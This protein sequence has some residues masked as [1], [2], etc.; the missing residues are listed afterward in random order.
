MVEHLVAIKGVVSSI[1]TAPTRLSAGL[2]T[3]SNL[4]LCFVG[5]RQWETNNAP[6]TQGSPGLCPL[7]NGY[8]TAA[9]FQFYVVRRSRIEP[10]VGGV[11]MAERTVASAMGHR[12]FHGMSDIMRAR[13]Q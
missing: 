13:G 4:E 6:S 3:F 1:L 9:L 12:W 10:L 2:R 5:N 7:L 11:M 8:F